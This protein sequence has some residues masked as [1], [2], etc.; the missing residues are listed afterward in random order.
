MTVQERDQ[1]LEAVDLLRAIGGNNGFSN[2]QPKL[3]RILLKKASELKQIVD[4]DIRKFSS[5]S[6]EIF[7]GE[8]VYED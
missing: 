6:S 4:D 3:K 2:L 8:T 1:I 5:H 7:E